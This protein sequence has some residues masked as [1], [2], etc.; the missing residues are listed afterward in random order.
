M[1]CWEIMN[2][3]VMLMTVDLDG[4]GTVADNGAGD[5]AG[6]GVGIGVGGGAGDRS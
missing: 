5:G 6:A 2:W 1:T 4:A 3:S